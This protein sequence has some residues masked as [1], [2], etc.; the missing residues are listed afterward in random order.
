MARPR[1][2]SESE[3]IISDYLYNKDKLVFDLVKSNKKMGI[4]GQPKNNN[5]NDNE[6]KKK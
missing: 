4:T 3:Q 1:K 2:L 5:N 6:T